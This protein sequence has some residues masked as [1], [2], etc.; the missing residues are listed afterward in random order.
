VARSASA[1][2]HRSSAVPS[3]QPSHPRHRREELMLQK[4]MLSSR[5]HHAR[6]KWVSRHWMSSDAQSIRALACMK[7]QYDRPSPDAR[8]ARRSRWLY[9]HRFRGSRQ[10]VLGTA[11][12]EMP[13]SSS[14]RSQRRPQWSQSSTSAKV[15]GE[16]RRQPECSWYRR[17]YEM[18]SSEALPKTS[19]P[20]IGRNKSL[21]L[22]PLFT[23]ASLVQS[24]SN[25]DHPREVS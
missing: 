2:Q 12:S 24:P 13:H 18:W 20:L 16:T 22:Q 25:T 3:K 19:I 8:G 10:H 6:S 1:S 14:A 7:M 9:Y 21:F 5:Q 17:P 11:K 15:K 23:Q 4:Q